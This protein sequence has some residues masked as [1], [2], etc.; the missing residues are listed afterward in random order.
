M[1]LVVYFI[2]CCAIAGSYL[3]YSQTSSSAFLQAE[4]AA[5][6][7]KCVPLRA[8]LEATRQELSYQQPPW[9]SPEYGHPVCKCVR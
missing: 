7:E 6:S 5:C 1:R 8:K 9:R 2:A 4:L 3:W